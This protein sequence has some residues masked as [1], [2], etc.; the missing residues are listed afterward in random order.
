MAT[1][2]DAFST[3]Y[4]KQMESAEQYFAFGMEAAQRILMAQM[5]GTRHIFEIQGRQFGALEDGAG[6]NPALQWANL[7]RRAMAGGTE[8]TEVWMRTF[9]TMQAEGLRVME[10]F[11]PMFNR[12]LMGSMERA[13]EVLAITAGKPESPRKRAA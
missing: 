3:A 13:S 12:S 11:F 2:Q 5:D 1:P 8:A 10:E 9:S 7:C 4:A 6:E